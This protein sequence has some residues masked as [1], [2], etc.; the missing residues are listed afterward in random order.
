MD[1]G[2]TVL[3]KESPP[4]DLVAVSVVIRAG[5]SKENEYLG[6]GITHFVEHMVFKGTASRGPGQI[7]RE[8]KSFGGAINGSVTQDFTTYYATVPAQYLPQVLSLLKDMLQ[9]AA[10]DAGEIEKEREVVLNEIGLGR[11]EPQ[12]YIVRLLNENAYMYH[13]YKYPVIGYDAP[14]KKL[15][16]E[17]LISYYQKMYV[18][19]N[20]IIAVVGGTTDQQVTALIEKEFADFRPADFRPSPAPPKEPLQIGRRSLEKEAEIN[21]AYLAMGFHSSS[22]LDK[23]IFALDCLAMILGR[24]DNAR[25]NNAL[26]KKMGIVHTITCWN[27]TPRDPGLFVVSALLSQY[28]LGPASKAVME[29]IRK[30]QWGQITDIEMETAKR[31]VLS[32]YIFSHQTVETQA[33]DISSSEVLTGNHQFSRRYVL[34][35]RSVTKYDV[36]RVAKKYLTEDN[37]T[38]IRLVPK[39]TQAAARAVTPQKLTIGPVK[40]FTLPNGMKLLVREDN[41]TPTTSLSVAIYGGLLT[42][43][44]AKNGISNLTASMLFKGTSARREHEI[45]GAFEERGG[46]ISPYSGLNSFGV[47]AMILKDDLYFALDIV[48]DIVT[49]ST[50][51]PEEVDRMKKL[52]KAQLKEEDDDL[53]MNAFNMMKKALF[54]TH[55]YH[56]RILGE[57]QT[58][59]Q[60]SREDLVSYYTTYC[61]PNN[62]VLSISGDVDT[63]VVVQR[64]GLLFGAMPK[65]EV[66]FPR[67]EPYS[68]AQ[69]ERRTMSMEKEESIV[70]LGFKTTDIKSRDRFALNVI[71][72]IMS[73]S[74]GRMFHELRDKMHIGYLLGCTQRFGVDTGY[75]TFYVFTTQERVKA[76]QESLNAMI[77]GLKTTEVSPEELSIAKRELVGDQAMR[78]QSNEYISSQCALDELYGLGFDAIFSFAQDTEAVTAQEVRQAAEKYFTPDS[79]AEVVITPP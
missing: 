17:D 56:M 45:R 28:N 46:T 9:N 53:F 79:C 14:L 50:F 37:L 26:F 16:R 55:P 20:V 30:V 4:K 32:D 77:A 36:M 40:E 78:M 27:Y 1:N 64:A 8:I 11:D 41:K 48:K 3:V 65:K 69:R 39:G 51:P 70:V 60:L 58:V 75:F 67:P 12:S 38:E 57:E 2:L 43:D 59:D 34:G 74:S 19:N 44:A 29:E 15:T 25:L 7:E 22:V 72:S 6:S 49:D 35:I 21:I 18:P 61:V 33:G 68:P 71:G 42:E 54:G 10:F 5:S 66:A 24:G 52:V 23:D 73:G 13:P 47:N 76:A 31:M 62:M 63:D